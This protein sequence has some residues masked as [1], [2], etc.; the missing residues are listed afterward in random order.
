MY[1]LLKHY[2]YNEACTSV[3][4]RLTFPSSHFHPSICTLHNM[5]VKEYMSSKVHVNR[6]HGCGEDATRAWDKADM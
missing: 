6:A 4:A 2:M 5:H 3:L 1:L